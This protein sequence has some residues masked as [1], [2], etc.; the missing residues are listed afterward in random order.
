VLHDFSLGGTERIAARLST[1]WAQAGAEVILFCGSEAGPLRS[2]V[3]D[4]VDVVA[5]PTPVARGTGSRRL[6]GRH[7]AA[8]FARHP[9]DLVWVPGNYHW[10]VIPELARIQ[11]AHRPTIVAQVSAALRKPQRGPIRQAGFDIRM[12]HLLRGAEE[13]VTLAGSVRHE[14]REILRHERVSHIPLPALDAFAPPPRPVPEGAPVILGAG[15]LVPEKGFANLIA[16]FARLEDRHARLV[17]AGDGPERENLQALADSLGVAARVTMPGYVR[18]IRPLLDQARLFVLASDY[19]GY[20]AVLIEALEAG[21]PVVSTDCTP[22]TV[23]LLHG[24]GV[25]H[26]VP[27]GDV[28]AMA[29]AIMSMLR[30]PAPAPAQLSARASPFRIDRIARQYLDLFDAV[31]V[32]AAV[33]ER[34]PAW[35]LAWPHR[36]RIV[37][38]VS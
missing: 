2:F 22:A 6:L 29:N 28:G 34:R 25:G 1:A 13:V 10:P 36:S 27:R 4:D 12:R 19:E 8:H 9:V 11:A 24:E 5:A 23:D 17:I 21:R 15:R 32:R 16:A 30:A 14:A 3:T 18:D 37:E 38:A 35:A 7:A 26:V 20:A 33:R 31:C